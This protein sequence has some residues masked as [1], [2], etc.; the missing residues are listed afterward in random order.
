MVFL[1]VSSRILANVE[2]LN[3]VESVGAYMRHRRAPIV[4]P[5]GDGF[6]LKYVPAVSGESLAHAYQELIASLAEKANINVCDNCKTG[7][8]IK[9]ADESV[10]ED[11]AKEALNR[12]KD[13]LERV[14]NFEKE[15]IARCVVE[16]IGGFLYAGKTPVKRT[17]RFQV[18]YMIPA[19]D[20]I[21]STAVEAQFHVRYAR[22]GE[23]ESIQKIYNVEVGSAVYTFGFNLDLDG[24]G[25]TSSAKVEQAVQPEEKKRRVDLAIKALGTMLSNAFLGAKRSRFTPVWKVLNAVAVVSDPIPITAEPPHTKNYIAN[26]VRKVKAAV[27]LLHS[28]KVSFDEH[29]WVGIY[30]SPEEALPQVEVKDVAVEEFDD[31]LSLFNKALSEILEQLKCGN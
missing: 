29:V 10:L 11:W 22:A 13:D 17:S 19:L 4:V 16:D 14:F 1:S 9:H 24:I 6:V 3:M 2:A 8:F 25:V 26:T 18:G 30:R 15:L 21:A 5:T 23:L 27:G 20:T 28:G 31:L 12:G 7:Y